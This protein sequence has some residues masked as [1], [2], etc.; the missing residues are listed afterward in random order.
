MIDFK[1]ATNTT[2]LLVDDDVQQLEWCALVLRMSGFSVITAV[3]PLEA[4]SIIAQQA[5]CKVDV[6]VIDYQ[7]PVMNG[8]VL[9]AYLRSRYPD[10]KIILHSGTIEIPASEMSNVDVFVPK[11]DGI[12]MLLAQVTEFARISPTPH[13]VLGCVA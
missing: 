4:M 11:S 5:A 6:A 1:V 12:G 10:L 3:G 9:A 13:G 8:C 7:L 2:L